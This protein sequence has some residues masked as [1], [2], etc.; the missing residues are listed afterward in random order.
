MVLNNKIPIAADAD[1]SVAAIVTAPLKSHP[2]VQPFQMRT[3]RNASQPGNGVIQR[4]AIKTGT[5]V[6][7]DGTRNHDIQEMEIVNALYQKFLTFSKRDFPS[8]PRIEAESNESR[9]NWSEENKLGEER[10]LSAKPLNDFWQLVMDFKKSRDLGAVNIKTKEQ[11][12]FASAVY[13]QY[14][15]TTANTGNTD[16]MV[17][18]HPDLDETEGKAASDKGVSYELAATK[19]KEIREATGW[20]DSDIAG[21][22]LQFYKNGQIPEKIEETG[23]RRNFGYLVTLMTVPESV[24]SV[25]TF[26]FGLIMLEN[27]K[28]SKANSA[29][30]FMAPEGKEAEIK[31]R[32]QIR[33]KNN[34]IKAAH[35]K[36]EESKTKV[37]EK[38]KEEEEIEDEASSGLEGLEP[39]EPVYKDAI[40]LGGVYAPA[41]SGSKKP[42][43]DLES[44]A[45]AGAL[46]SKPTS[47]NQVDYY[48]NI[49]L[50]RYEK[51]VK[52]YLSAHPEQLSFVEEI[53][54]RSDAINEVIN[55]ILT[56]FGVGEEIVKA[57]TTNRQI[58]RESN[59][60]ISSLHHI[61]KPLDE[62]GKYTSP[63][64]LPPGG[65]LAAS[66]FTFGAG[67]GVEEEEAVFTRSLYETHTNTYNRFGQSLEE[68]PLAPSSPTQQFGEF[69][70]A[71]T[72]DV[73]K[74]RNDRK[75]NPVEFGEVFSND[76]EERIEE[77]KTRQAAVHVTKSVV[78]DL[79][80]KGI[81]RSLGEDK[82]K[83]SLEEK[84]TETGREVKAES[85]KEPR[86]S[87]GVL[88]KRGL[89]L[90]IKS[91]IHDIITKSW[92]EDLDFDVVVA[93]LLNNS[94]WKEF[95]NST[96]LPEDR[97]TLDEEELKKII[98]DTVKEYYI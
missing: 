52:D 28:N 18:K 47:A 19:F 70:R 58:K 51:M 76:L 89:I 56:H 86:I 40:D 74:N 81:K 16:V 49:T 41:Y 93:T 44:V 45:E 7:P 26:P 61:T 69:E 2:A 90:K 37:V 32:K 30:A 85:V 79:K 50:G 88:R 60:I 35:K 43:N 64:L 46:Q 73:L 66:I 20:S 63:A 77:L 42:L 95:I 97:F 98:S 54:L 33:T 55:Q 78:S 25:G 14:N 57:S 13:N 84:G 4:V 31:R 39:V 83:G 62:G 48:W 17:Y 59:R 87:A 10:V 96:L 24:R 5:G 9:T 82:E 3:G 21:S 27:I 94:E 65:E 1:K 75:R 29:Q 6:L 68:Y 80:K 8:N 34:K 23:Q 53:P 12:G 92:K 91:V 67:R 15:K 11:E 22:I 38:E 36:K 71:L 72:E